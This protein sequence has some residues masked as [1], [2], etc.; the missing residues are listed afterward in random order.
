VFKTHEI[1]RP[2]L[3]ATRRFA[4]DG[5]SVQNALELAIAGY[6]PYGAVTARGLR[7]YWAPAD[8]EVARAEAKRYFREG[9]RFV[10]PSPRAIAVSTGGR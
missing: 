3:R 8:P 6:V 10:D 5:L 1:P 9:Y 2:I 4:L 7:I